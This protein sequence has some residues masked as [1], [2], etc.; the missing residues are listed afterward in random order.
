MASET[1]MEEV[2]ADESEVKGRESCEQITGKRKRCEDGSREPP[3]K[4]QAIVDEIDQ[5]FWLPEAINALVRKG[6]KDPI[7]HILQL[8][9]SDNSLDMERFMEKVL[10]EMGKDKQTE[11]KSKIESAKPRTEFIELCFNQFGK[12]KRK[13]MYWFSSERSAALTLYEYLT[14]EKSF[15]R[16]YKMVENACGTCS[17]FHPMI[18]VEKEAN[19]YSHRTFTLDDC[20]NLMKQNGRIRISDTMFLK[21]G[22][23]VCNPTKINL[24]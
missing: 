8:F 9:Q 24:S 2:K 20:L 16:E 15:Q 4:K 6:I 18:L 12:N 3:E 19:E 14:K 10:C 1:P 23:F 5:S 17:N 7:Y 11:W 22:R 13:Q 21:I